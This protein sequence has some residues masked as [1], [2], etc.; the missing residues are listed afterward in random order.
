MTLFTGKSDKDI[1]SEL[2]FLIS[3]LSVRQI[4]LIFLRLEVSFPAI[5]FVFLLNQSASVSLSV[6]LSYQWTSI[7][8]W[9]PSI[10]AKR[11]FSLSTF[12]ASSS[13]NRHSSSDRLRLWILF[14]FLFHFLRNVSL[15]LAPF[16]F[17]W[18]IFCTRFLFPFLSA[19]SS[20]WLHAL[21]NVCFL[22]SFLAQRKSLSVS[23]S[24]HLHLAR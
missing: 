22:F 9:S 14:S 24:S 1:V 2:Q 13:I 4:V 10:F 16:L 3:L 19:L 17:S 6:I 7:E 11:Y 21:K 12:T 8:S 15:R 23:L 5:I 20:V 18:T